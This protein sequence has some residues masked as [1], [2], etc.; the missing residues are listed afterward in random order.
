MEHIRLACLVVWYNWILTPAAQYLLGT[1]CHSARPG[2]AVLV[3]SHDALSGKGKYCGY[4]RRQW[5]TALGHILET[6]GNRST[7]EVLAAAGVIDA[8]EWKL[9]YH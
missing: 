8:G 7:S 2:W 3:T 4:P 5:V 1:R 9:G 6:T